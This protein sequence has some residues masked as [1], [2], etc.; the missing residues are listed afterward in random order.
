MDVFVVSE[1]FAP[2]KNVSA[3]ALADLGGGGGRAHGTP[4][5]GPN[6]FI[7]A[8]IFRGRSRGARAPLDHQK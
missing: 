5:T 3:P 2:V 1:Y 6:Y 4:P 7:F 8:Y